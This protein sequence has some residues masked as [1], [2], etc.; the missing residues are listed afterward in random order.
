MRRRF[1][2]ATR[3]LVTGF[4]CTS[5][6]DCLIVVT[7]TFSEEPIEPGMAV[8]GVIDRLALAKQMQEILNA[9]LRPSSTRK[10]TD[11]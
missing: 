3:G 10:E 8:L 7:P 5:R 4:E 9:A 11:Q 1:C 2:K 6:I